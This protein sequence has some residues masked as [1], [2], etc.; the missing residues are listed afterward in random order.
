MRF[1]HL[2]GRHPLL[3]CPCATA[4]LLLI[5]HCQTCTATLGKC[6][7]RTLSPPLPEP[8]LFHA[9]DYPF[10]G[11]CA[12]AAPGAAVPCDKAGLAW[13]GIGAEIS[14]KGTLR[15]SAL[16]TGGY[17][18]SESPIQSIQMFAVNSS[19]KFHCLILK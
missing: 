13:L 19:P 1:Y 15:A 6:V 8:D 16:N 5:G 11:L 17:W 18:L 12:T 14:A 10:S 7:C 4:T 2:T 3:G 9:K